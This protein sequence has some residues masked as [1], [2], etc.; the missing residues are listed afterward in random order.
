VAVTPEVRGTPLSDTVKDK[1]R[2]LVGEVHEKLAKV[3]QEKV[4]LGLNYG[5]LPGKSKAKKKV[6]QTTVKK[7]SAEVV[8]GEEGIA[9]PFGHQKGGFNRNE[10]GVRAILPSVQ[11]GEQTRQYLTHVSELFFARV[12]T[13]E[14]EGMLVNDRLLVSANET[15]TV[16][17]IA[18]LRLGDLLAEAAE[19]PSAEIEVIAD[20]H[21]T[22]RY[23]IGVMGEALKLV[24][25]G[26]KP[27]EAQ[28]KG[29]EVLAE[30]QT[31][32]HV[33]YDA[34]PMLESFVR[35]LQTQV[36]TITKVRGPYSI[37]D[38]AEKIKDPEFK[39]SVIAVKALEGGK[40]HAEQHLALAYVKSKTSERA[41][42]AGTKIPCAVCWL[43]LA[44]VHK[45]GRN[46][47]FNNTP[48]GLWDSTVYRG[49]SAVANELKITDATQLW[50]SFVESYQTL[51][52]E[53][54]FVQYLTALRKGTELIVTIPKKGGG[55]KGLGYTQD[56]SGLHREFIGERPQSPLGESFPETPLSPRGSYG[57]PPH[58]DDESEAED[59][60]TVD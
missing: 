59:E 19:D 22:R 6:P 50:E 48:G 26:S 1:K 2:K 56:I 57:T 18:Q 58:S 4:V 10:S 28:R 9:R 52:D 40:S 43:T 8:K 41:A 60:E 13:M 16:T 51:L 54:T 37:E 45:A 46:L 11:I 53:D 55:L 29:V 32:F 31:G 24:E 38:A 42:V 14:V 21:K 23:R 47:D 7:K 44:L 49:L 5:T 15:A 27:T 25:Q 12:S 39:H 36:R 30:A 33:D 17:K 20:A 34:R 3:K 35:T